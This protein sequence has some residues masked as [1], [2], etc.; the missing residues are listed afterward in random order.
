MRRMARKLRIE[1]PGAIYHVM[2]R[3]DRQ[4]PIFEDDAD[5]ERFLETLA[6]DR[7]TGEHGL[8]RGGLGSAAQRRCREREDRAAVPTGNDGQQ[9]MD[10]ETIVDGVGEQCDVLPEAGQEAMKTVNYRA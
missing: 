8:G 4:E 6:E 3:G 5:R 7:R 10:C 9:T 1:Y 2:N